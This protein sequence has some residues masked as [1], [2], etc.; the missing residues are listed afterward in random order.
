METMAMVTTAMMT[1]VMRLV[2]GDGDDDN[3]GEW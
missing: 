3:D 1:M 2:N